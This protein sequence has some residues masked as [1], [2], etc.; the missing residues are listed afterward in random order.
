MKRSSCSESDWSMLDTWEPVC[1]TC[2]QFGATSTWR[3]C[4]SQ[5]RASYSW[6]LIRVGGNSFLRIWSFSESCSSEKTWPLLSIYKLT[7]S[8]QY[9]ITTERKRQRIPSGSD[10]VSSSSV[11]QRYVDYWLLVVRVKWQVLLCSDKDVV[12]MVIIMYYEK[13]ITFLEGMKAIFFK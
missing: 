8:F 1:G 5:S 2:A 12:M 13:K 11:R 6:N 9:R 4:P 3:G 10:Y 7:G